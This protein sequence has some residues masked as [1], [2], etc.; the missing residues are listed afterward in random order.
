MQTEAC[1]L[2]GMDINPS[3]LLS[4]A[5]TALRLSVPK[6]K[7]VSSEFITLDEVAWH[8]IETDCWIVIYDRV[9]DVTEFF[10][11]H[12]GGREVLLE[13]AGRDATIAFRGVGH[14]MAAIKALDRFLIGELPLKERIFRKPG[15]IRLSDIPV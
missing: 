11:E 3:G 5:M 2:A 15:G 7:I 13:Y 10:N 1:P 12:P 9:Y 6:E 14:S 4:L 8:D